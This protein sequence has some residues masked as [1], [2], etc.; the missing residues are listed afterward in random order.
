MDMKKILLLMCMAVC[1]FSVCMQAQNTFNFPYSE[2]NGKIVISQFQSLDGLAEDDIFLNA[3]L[4]VIQ[5]GPQPEEKVLQVDY[6]KRQ[7]IV[8][9]ILENPKTSSHY[10]H[11]LSV[12]VSDNIIT[13]LISDITY[14]AETA[15]IKL[16]KRLPFDKLQPDKKPKHKV[17]MDDFANM[18]KECAE[19]MF[20]FIS[21]NQLSAIM[22]WNEIKSKGAVKGMNQNECLLSLGKPASIQK[23]G[24]K[25]EWMYDTYTYLF[26]EN[27]IVTSV[28]K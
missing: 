14:E 22:H 23:Q 18:Y 19:Q 8:N 5:N 4:W 17:L 27:G 26:F 16:V 24:N 15:V 11:S 7:F 1:C 12:R 10:R 28:I 21:T 3:L 25:E 20:K 6:D 9:L 2:V 13:M